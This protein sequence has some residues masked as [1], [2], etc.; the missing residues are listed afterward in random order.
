MSAS[1]DIWKML[2]GVAI[3]LLG[4]G[5]IEESLRSLAG[6]KFKLFLKKQTDNTLKAIGG[7]AIVT[8]LLQS[9][10]IVNLLTLS[11]VGAGV[12]KMKNALAI[13]LG[14]NLGTT[15]FN[16]VVATVGF[17][18]NIENLALPVAGIAG[19]SLTFFNTETRWYQWCKFL[20]GLSFLFIGLGF[21]KEGMQEVVSHTDLSQF[22]D[23]P[24]IIFFLVGLSLTAII[25]ASSATV[26]LTLSALYT[27]AIT[28]YAATAI[29]LG[30]E[31][32]TIVKLFLA[33]AKGDPVKKRVAL[34]NFL[35]NTA[36]VVILL[37]LLR[38]VNWFITDTL[39]IHDKLV[40][41]VLFQ[42]LVNITS[43]ILFYPLLNVMGRFLEKRFTA[44]G[45][46]SAFISKVAVADTG[47][48]LEAMEKETRHF[49]FHVLYF[50]TEAMG[51]TSTIPEGLVHKN[52]RRK[53][54]MEKYEYIKHLHGEIH[55]FYIRLQNM[56]TAKSE[57]ERIE[58]LIASV[59]NG[60]YAAKN[61]RD[62]LHDVEQL[63]NSSNDTK[64]RFYLETRDKLAAFC[65]EVTELT[66]NS[67]T[68]NPS[69][70]I[71]T[72]Y[73]DI[74]QGYTKSL[75]ELYKLG[76]S[77]HV[78]E[79][80]IS[81]LINFNREMYTAFKSLVFAVKDY[82]LNPEESER[83]DNVPGFIR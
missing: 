55:G 17:S 71:T 20:V 58:Q 79:P 67:K 7:G 44:E 28:L 10:S 52:F 56:A 16:W 3:F 61:I 50:S 13:M 72:L 5:F 6:R 77:Q 12:L 74:Q 41:L 24:V 31:I 15:L 53:T 60:M 65:N 62:A 49:I 43:I 33:A 11:M 36:T 26:A 47:M 68:G 46:E 81:T 19:I 57:T 35:F 8:A 14:S 80:E 42:S 9:S 29:V 75:E 2:A 23:Y 38:P 27:N 66:E 51:T 18:I 48:A 69:E 34:G 40:A 25:Q 70:K 83:F 73:R 63:R 1:F 32:G 37:F 59:R 78:N 82:I 39:A 22:N 64:Y 4:I 76:M 54:I 30:A 45:D 21:I